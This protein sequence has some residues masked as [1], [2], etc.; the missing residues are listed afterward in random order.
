MNANIE[1]KNIN[2]IIEIKDK[3]LETLDTYTI[4]LFGSYA[5]GIPKDDSDYDI[6]AM[7]KIY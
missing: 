7:Q 1:I 5:Y 6:Y 4:Y 3:I 2:N